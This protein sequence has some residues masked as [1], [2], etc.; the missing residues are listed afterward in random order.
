[1]KTFLNEK[2]EK[3]GHK[4]IN[5]GVDSCDSVDYPDYAKKVADTV[6]SGTAECGILICGTGIGISIAANKINGIR[7]ALCHTEF[8]ARMAKLHNNANV[9]ALAG[10]VIGLDL[11]LAITRAYLAEDF[12]REPDH[13]TERTP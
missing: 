9:L 11:S 5:C 2:L 6:L 8:S 7:S 10:R 4:I 3:D 1:M 13:S 12:S